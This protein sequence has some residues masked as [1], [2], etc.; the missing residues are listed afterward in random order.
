MSSH[1]D[2]QEAEGLTVEEESKCKEAF[3]AFDKENTGIIDANELRI[4]LEMMG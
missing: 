4:V 1:D 2:E 3:A